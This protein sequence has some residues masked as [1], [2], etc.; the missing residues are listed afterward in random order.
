VSQTKA[1]SVLI[2][3][4]GQR[5]IQIHI[6]DTTRQLTDTNEQTARQQHNKLLQ[7]RPRKRQQQECARES[8]SS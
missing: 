5:H 4:T 6:Q 7:T 1:G 8:T 2:M 3:K